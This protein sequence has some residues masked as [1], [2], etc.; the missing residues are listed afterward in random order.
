MKL[1]N[2]LE[3]ERKFIIDQNILKNISFT[4]S[5]KITSGYT[6]REV[7]SRINL[8]EGNNYKKGYCTFKGKGDIQRT[9]FEYE[10]PFDHAKSMVMDSSICP[11]VIEKYRYEVF[12]NKKLWEIDQYITPI[13][14][15]SVLIYPLVA[16]VEL[17]SIDED[18]E[19]PSWIKK[20]ITKINYFKNHKLAIFK[21][22]PEEFLYYFI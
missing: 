22:L 8:I 13:N 11:Y 15:N 4:N 1:I 3:I 17:S 18:L 6:S 2:N 10:I 7:E 12:I 9:E 20:E 5:Y 14:C 16:E 19:L 21:D